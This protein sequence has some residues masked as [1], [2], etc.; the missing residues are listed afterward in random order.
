[1]RCRN[2]L[3]SNELSLALELY[4]RQNDNQATI[5]SSTGWSCWVPRVCAL[6]GQGRSI[7][8]AAARL[9]AYS[10]LYFLANITGHLLV[11]WQTVKRSSTNVMRSAELSTEKDHPLQVGA[12]E[13]GGDRHPLWMDAQFHTTRIAHI[14][15]HTHNLLLAHTRS[16]IAKHRK[17]QLRLAKSFTWYN[18]SWLIFADKIFIFFNDFRWKKPLHCTRAC[19]CDA[20]PSTGWCTLFV[21]N[22]FFHFQLLQHFTFR[23]RPRRT[24]G[25]N[26][27]TVKV[28]LYHRFSLSF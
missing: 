25:E 23:S 28:K 27:G 19:V 24:L 10:W 1:M 9:L 14:W 12:G 17:M 20:P 8:P 18:L 13:R 11:R 6:Y 15:R 7:N 3:A 2:C 16:L 21:V 5:S 4:R 22:S 26:I